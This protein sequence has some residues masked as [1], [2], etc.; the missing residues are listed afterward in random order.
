MPV[1]RDLQSFGFVYGV[2]GS[3]RGTSTASAVF[4][5]QTQFAKRCVAA[6]AW[7]EGGGLR[8]SALDPAVTT[9][10]GTFVLFH[11]ITPNGTIARFRVRRVRMLNVAGGTAAYVPYQHATAITAI[12][13][14]YLAFG[15]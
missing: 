4:A 3:T 14:R 5:I 11:P 7:E 13:A 10:V 12:V 2:Y 9:A 8:N 6:F 15:Y 1:S